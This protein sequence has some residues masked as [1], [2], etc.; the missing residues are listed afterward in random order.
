MSPLVLYHNGNSGPSRFI[1][2]LIR[3]LNLD[4]EIRTV[5]LRNKE[6]LKP[7]F[8]K[9]N[10]QHTVPTIDDNG[11]I[12]WESVAIAEYIIATYAHE[13]SLYPKDI[14]KRAVVSQRLQ[15]YVGT[16]LQRVRLVT[17]PIMKEG[18]KTI[19]ELRRAQLYEAFE[20]AEGFLKGSDW[21]AGDQLTLADLAVFV[22]IS[23]IVGFGADISSYPNLTS[24]VER[25]KSLPGYEENMEGVKSYAALFKTMY[26]GKI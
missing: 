5:D 22:V 23:T 9:I 15:F 18:E 7:E 2:M 11:F 6:Q 25:C 24:W 26:N 16:L 19:P 3:S 17:H 1:L 20:L 14:K 12:L 10:P 8:L 4:V 21:I 13:S